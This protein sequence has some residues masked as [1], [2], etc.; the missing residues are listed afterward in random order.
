MEIM[1]SASTWLSGSDAQL[2]CRSILH[3]V[4]FLAATLAGKKNNLNF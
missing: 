1:F 2:S 3:S 4:A